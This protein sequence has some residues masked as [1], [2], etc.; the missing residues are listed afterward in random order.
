MSPTVAALVSA[1]CRRAPVATCQS[2]LAAA[3]DIACGRPARPVRTAARPA[4][5]GS[6]SPLAR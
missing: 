1:L 5:T 6:P 4:R 3:I 2:D